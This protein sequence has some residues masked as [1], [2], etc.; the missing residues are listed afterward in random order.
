MTVMDPNTL[1]ERAVGDEAAYLATL[2][3]LVEHETPTGDRDLAQRMANHL[4]ERLEQDGWAVRR[5]PRTGVGDVLVARVDGGDPKDATLILAH[6][7]TVWPEGTL[8]EMP[9]RH[10]GDVIHGPGVLDM[11]AGIATALHGVKLAREAGPLRGPVTLLLTSDEESGSAHSR[12]EIEEQAKKHARVLVVEPGRDDGA[13][14]VGRKGVGEFRVVFTGR[15][16]HAGNDPERGASALRELAHFLLFA[17]SLAD[18]DAQTTVAVTVAS[19]GTVVNVVAERAEAR[20]DLRVLRPGEADRVATAL[21]SY[22]PRDER[23]R[24]EVSGGSNRPPLEPTAM[25]RELFEEAVRH[26]QA[27]DLSLEGAVVG[28]GSDGNFTSAM[29]VPTLDGLGS[30][31]AGPHAR[32][33][34][35]R[36]RETLERVALVASLLRAHGG[37]GAS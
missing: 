32:N 37:R 36:V 4:E 11:K 21:R 23:V 34:H 33:E 18:P 24:V 26:L 2:R 28:G 35:V 7:D 13:L 8:S 31:G 3:A 16:A 22:H 30:A 25:N 12:E 10:E 5:L 29:N 19:G 15:G 9:W 6:Y 1:L 20:V 17:E 27:M 14:K